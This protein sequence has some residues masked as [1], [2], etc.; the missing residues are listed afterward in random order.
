MKADKIRPILLILAAFAA[1]F[2]FYVQSRS[3]KER[4]DAKAK[5]AQAKKQAIKTKPVI[6]WAVFKDKNEDFQLKYPAHWQIEDHS[7]KDQLVRADISK[8]KTA[9]VQVR[10]QKNMKQEFKAFTASYLDHFTDDMTGHWK[11]T[12]TLISSK[13]EKIGT[14]HGFSAALVLKRG[15]GQKWFLKQFLW[16]KGDKVYILQSGAEYNKVHI[17]E[18]LFD[19]IAGS[20]KLLE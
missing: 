3:N 7:D 17:Y 13:F 10:V 8:D 1:M 9:G 2:H 16:N 14:H 18:P 4:A 20:F 11:G 12:T 19:K 6:K 15:D 5:I